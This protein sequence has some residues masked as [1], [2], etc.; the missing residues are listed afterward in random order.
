MEFHFEVI[1]LNR[2]NWRDFVN[3]PSPVAAALM[4]KMNVAPTDRSRV[5]LECLRLL[6]TLRLNQAKMKL[7]SGFVDKYLKLGAQDQVEFEAEI[8]G[9]SPGEKEEVMEIV[10]SWM[11]DGL[12]QGRREGRKQG[13]HKG[14]QQGLKQGRREGAEQGRREGVEQGQLKATRDDI[15]E[16]LEVRFNRVPP[17]VQ[18]TLK[19]IDDR[20]RLKLLLREAAS[21]ASLKEFQRRLADLA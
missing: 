8:K 6:A 1:Q 20:K 10:T 13:L 11:E 9:L 5:K 17:G 21:A 12:K 3:R 18:K 19:K 7:I 4:A 15:V 16:I 14:L 2:L